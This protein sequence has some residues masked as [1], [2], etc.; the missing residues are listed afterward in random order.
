ME[1]AGA[2][3][4]CGLAVASA[5][6]ALFGLWILFLSH[7]LCHPNDNSPATTGTADQLL[8]R[9]GD[10]SSG[11]GTHGSGDIATA[12]AQ[13]KLLPANFLS[14]KDYFTVMSNMPIPT[15]DVLLVDRDATRTLLFKRSNKPVQHV[16][17]SLGGRI[18][19]NERVEVAAGR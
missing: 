8:L 6:F 11:D 14:N 2:P 1:I 17:Y 10:E 3:R 15:V 12:E 18:Y 5:L 9:G 4:Q 7:S 16:Y 13:P 19:K